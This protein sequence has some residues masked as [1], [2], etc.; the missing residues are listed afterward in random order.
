MY[1]AIYIQQGENYA[2]I[3]HLR[4]DNED[5]ITKDFKPTYYKTDPNGQYT[6]LDGKKVSPTY[7]YSK[8]N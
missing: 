1:Q 3:I 5:W 2:K 6:T 8:L 4:D 7:K